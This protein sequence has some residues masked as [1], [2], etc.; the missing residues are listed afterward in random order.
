MT[1]CEHEWRE[2]V[3]GDTYCHKCK[4]TYA[5]FNYKIGF[6]KGKAEQKMLDIKEIQ[7]RRDFWIK[8]GK[9][10]ERRLQTSACNVLISACNVLIE[11]E[12]TRVLNEV[13]KVMD[14]N[15]NHCSCCYRNREE[16]AKL[17]VSSEAKKT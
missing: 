1:T 5:D 16:W 15:Q 12:R 2:S 4:I 7:E 13:W 10:E 14:F 17:R 8:E 11:A 3:L 6:E 9:A